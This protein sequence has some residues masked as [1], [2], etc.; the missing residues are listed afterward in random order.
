MGRG[1]RAWAALATGALAA[2][3][4]AACATGG[5]ARP[6]PDMQGPADAVLRHIG[7]RAERRT[8][9]Y[10]SAGRTSVDA[11]VTLANEPLY[12]KQR[13]S[14][15]T[16]RDEPAPQAYPRLFSPALVSASAWDGNAVPTPGG[17][18]GGGIP[19]W[20]ALD[21]ATQIAWV[22]PVVLQDP[23][24]LADDQ[25]T[26]VDAAWREL[27]RIRT[28]SSR[29]GRPWT[30]P[31]SK[32]A[33]RRSG[34][35]DGHSLIEEFHPKHRAK[36][37]TARLAFFVQSR[38]ADGEPEL[39][40]PEPAVPVTNGNY[41]GR[42]SAG[43]GD[44][45][46]RTEEAAD[47]G[48]VS[49]QSLT[50][51]A[52]EL[53]LA[54]PEVN[55][56]YSFVMLHCGV[57]ASYAGDLPGGSVLVPADAD[58]SRYD[59]VSRREV[60]EGFYDVRIVPRVRVLDDSGVGYD[61]PDTLALFAQYLA[62]GR[63]DD[64]SV[65]ITAAAGA[66]A[67]EVV[68]QRDA[69]AAWMRRAA[70]AVETWY[71][72][73]YRRDLLERVSDAFDDLADEIAHCSVVRDGWVRLDSDSLG[74]VA[75]LGD[76]LRTVWSAR[77]NACPVAFDDARFSTPQTN[78]GAARPGT[79][80]LAVLGARRDIAPLRPPDV[81]QGRVCGLLRE[82]SG[83]GGFVYVVGADLQFSR[84]PR[85][86]NDF[87]RMLDPTLEKAYDDAAD[88]PWSHV[89]GTTRCEQLR[90]LVDRAKF[91]VL[92]GDVA[93]GRAGSNP[94]NFISSAL[95][96][97]GASSPYTRPNKRPWDLGNGLLCD[98]F[99]PDR[100]EIEDRGEFLSIKSQF[101]K[102]RKPVFAVPGNH[103]GYVQT[104]GTPAAFIAFIGRL[105]DGVTGL[106]WFERTFYEWLPTIFAPPAPTRAWVR[107]GV[108]IEERAEEYYNPLLWPVYDGLLEWQSHLGPLNFSF[109]YRGHQFVGLNTYAHPWTTRDGFGPAVFYG[110][111]GVESNDVLW[112]RA[113]MDS[114][115]AIREAVDGSSSAMRG[116]TLFLHHDPRGAYPRESDTVGDKLEGRDRDWGRYDQ[117]EA[118]WQ[119]WSGGY[120]GLG[121]APTVGLIWP[122]VTPGIHLLLRSKFFERGELME[123]QL[124]NEKDG[125]ASGARELLAAVRDHAIST[126]T[127]DPAGNYAFRVFEGHNDV[128]ARGRW[129]KNGDP[130]H[131]QPVDESFPSGAP[132]NRFFRVSSGGQPPWWEE[133]AHPATDEIRLA[134]LNSL[135]DVQDKHRGFVVVEVRPGRH[136]RV[137]HVPLPMRAEDR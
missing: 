10:S 114:G 136:P 71:Q 128:Y 40:F 27:D 130:F 97:S 90:A 76:A 28:E 54:N 32:G 112:A 95:G 43:G 9:E 55:R 82:E 111:G 122:G 69:A 119:T 86:L 124:F 106:D 26:D 2:L 8:A 58:A 5:D 44:A 24:L 83:D 36:F 131:G 37:L 51:E 102:I 88:D 63:L 20:A 116:T 105:I 39:A 100:A 70:D 11:Y 19:P 108:P 13:L 17:L 121:H 134:R 133:V 135:G 22:T 42:R 53:T 23:Y 115:A 80:Q 96:L 127:G 3:T 47:L 94:A 132:W 99:S 49:V 137:Q 46:T 52:T 113:A 104:A 126:G 65:Y 15:F 61:P 38:R 110:G 12:L 59:E 48:A 25:L 16:H 107:P 45:F 72:L 60:E 68:E 120:A 31:L 118:F 129:S 29:E 93:D 74:A 91:V 66:G 7:R 117:V 75:R 73:P 18:T 62:E 78:R 101:A 77:A 85:A 35:G 6:Y 125:H 64:A 21:D 57:P 98:L 123:W 103:D 33:S 79:R 109:S 89:S 84:D 81:G 92:A 50:D 1:C 56:V 30:G 67:P 34:L 87:A 4:T 14:P 41:F